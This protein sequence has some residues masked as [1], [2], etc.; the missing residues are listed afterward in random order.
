MKIE[1]ILLLSFLILFLSV[2]ESLATSG[3]DVDFPNDTQTQDVVYGGAVQKVEQFERVGYA[4][5]DQ[6][7]DYTA[8]EKVTQKK[9]PETQIPLS[10]VPIFS[11][12]VR[13]STW[14]KC[15]DRILHQIGKMQC[16]RVQLF[17]SIGRI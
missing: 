7:A 11:I 15:E 16:W 13:L 14:R 2:A 3:T 10:Q 17:P 1:Q 8:F 6:R 5:Y 4:K 12:G 9:Q